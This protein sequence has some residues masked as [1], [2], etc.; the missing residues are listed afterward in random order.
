MPPDLQHHNVVVEGVFPN[1]PVHELRRASATPLAQNNHPAHH[2]K[3]PK[4]KKM[5]PDVEQRNFD[6]KAPFFRPPCNPC[7]LGDVL[8]Q[9]NTPT[10]QHSSH[11]VCPQSLCPQFVS[12]IRVHN[13][14]PQFVSTICVHN[15]CPHFV[16]KIRVHKLCPQF[17]S[18]IRVQNLCP[19]FASKICVHNLCPQFVSTICVHSSCPQFVSKIR[20]HCPQF[21]STICVQN[22]CP[23]MV[24]AKGARRPKTRPDGGRTNGRAIK[25]NAE[26]VAIPCGLSS[27]MQFSWAPRLFFGPSKIWLRRLPPLPPKTHPRGARRDFLFFQKMR[28]WT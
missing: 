15:S 28:F 14:C 11:K 20:V 1:H 18:A 5:H 19:Q 17:M 27:V 10:P 8:A 6:F 25:K 26:L 24:S 22:L 2:T 23:Q 9:K 16:S 12:T 7:A 13:L 21:V 3:T 4:N